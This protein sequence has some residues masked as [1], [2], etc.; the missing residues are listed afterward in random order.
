VC[1]TSIPSSHSRAGTPDKIAVHN[2][3]GV[4]T[5]LDG[6]ERST[7]DSFRRPESLLS[8]PLDQIQLYDIDALPLFSRASL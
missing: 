2:T 3:T 6:E 7:V 5:A 4:H 8:K 1:L